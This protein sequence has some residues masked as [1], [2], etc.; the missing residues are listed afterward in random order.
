M[1]IIVVTGLSGSGKSTALR[2]LEDVGFY[3]MDNVPISEI[4]RLVEYL[5]SKQITMIAVSVDIRQHLFGSDYISVFKELNKNYNIEVL[6]LD[7]TDDVLIRR[8]SETRRKHPLAGDVLRKDIKKDRDFVK[9][10]QDDQNQ[11]ILDTSRMTV[12]QLKDIIQERYGRKEGQ[13]SVTLLSFGFKYGIPVEADMVMDC[14]FLPN[15]YFVETLSKLDGKNEK[16]SQ[17][18]LGSTHGSCFL[19]HVEDLV[20]FSL[21][22]FEKERK[23]YT[24]I[25]IGCTGGQHRSVASVEEI[26]KRLTP[27]WNV[28][29]RHRD[30]LNGE[31]YV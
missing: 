26:Y 1:K 4:V 8:F 30:I 14:R 5:S 12:H 11:T 27:R 25:A 31:S 21:P 19:K 22:L 20:T 16:V 23:L 17:F 13:L 6:F 3:C 7:S 24:T 28:L 2:A 18:V 9:C 10:F 29:I 15:P